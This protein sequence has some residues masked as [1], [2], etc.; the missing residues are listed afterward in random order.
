MTEQHYL[1]RKEAAQYLRTLGIPYSPATLSKKAT[2]GGG[3]TYRKIGRH[4]LY[5]K[6][7]LHRWLESMPSLESAQG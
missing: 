1:T 3:P 4:C 5:T 7:D 2:V 6:E